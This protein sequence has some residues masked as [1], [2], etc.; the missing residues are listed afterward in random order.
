MREA[1][2]VTQWQII[3]PSW[4]NDEKFEVRATMPVGTPKDVARL[5]L[6]RMLYERFGLKSHVERRITNT[7]ALIV[8]KSGLKLLEVEKGKAYVSASSPGTLSVG[9][10]LMQSLAERLTT[11]SEHPVVDE[12]GLSGTYGIELKWTPDYGG[13]QGGR[14]NIGV[15]AVLEAQ[16]GLK[17]EPRRALVEMIVI[18]YINRRPTSN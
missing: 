2:S 9:A 18:D 16:L 13:S 14:Q 8:A 10:M 17:L 6:R 4:L 12:T 15:L 3:G 11:I 1:F 5:M 7:H